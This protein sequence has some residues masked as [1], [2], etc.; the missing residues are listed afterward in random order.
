[1]VGEVLR[2][3]ACPHCAAELTLAGGV[4]R[5]AR[6]HGFDVAKQGYVNLSPG[7][8]TVTGDSPA[9]VAARADFLAAGHFQPIS[10][11]VAAAATAALRSPGCVVDLGAGTGHHLAAVLDAAPD[12]HGL[13]LEVAKPA[14]RRAARAHPR[15]GA[16]GC[17]TRD[18]LPLRDGAAAV[19]L[20][21]FA[22]RNAAETHRVLDGAGALVVASPTEAHLRELVAALDLLTVD[23]DKGRRL[24]DGLA[25][26]FELSTQDKVEFTMSLSRGEVE[27]LVAMGPSAWHIEADE[28]RARVRTLAEPVG[29]TAS[30]LVS[31]FDRRTG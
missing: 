12:R 30:V 28:L 11:A 26:W 1:V 10:A 18:R 29:V 20:S 31:T 23:P 27:H 19:A 3:L 8:V 17:D 4:V 22:P 2:Y 15:M 25:P 24:A 7:R 13:A 21:V 6:G 14:L 16:I 9:M 5:C